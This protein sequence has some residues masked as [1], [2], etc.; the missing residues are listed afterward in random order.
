MVGPAWGIAYDSVQVGV[1]FAP[2][3]ERVLD[4]YAP[5]SLLCADDESGSKSVPFVL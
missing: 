3:R 4:G 2:E 5:A 1:C